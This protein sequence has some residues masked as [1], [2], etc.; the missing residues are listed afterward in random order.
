MAPTQIASRARQVLIWCFHLLLLVTP[1]LFTWF[2]EEL[3]EFNKMLFVYGITVLIAAAWL[4]KT[5]AIGKVEL[6][7]S[8]FTLLLG[9]FI[10]SQVLSTLFSIHVPTS[11]FG[12]YT[13]FNG[14]LLSLISYSVLY[15]IALQEIT[16]QEVKRLLTTLALAGLGIA[17]FAI[18]EHF[19]HAWSCVLIRQEFTTSCWVQDVQ[20]RI[21]GTFGQPNWLAAY[22]VTVIPVILAQAHGIWT[23]KNKS[24][25]LW[26]FSGVATLLTV[27]LIFTKS[28]SGW[29][30]LLAAMGALLGGAVWLWHQHRSKN[31]KQ[32]LPL[33][34]F[35]PLQ[36]VG[37]ALAVLVLL[38]VVFGNP[39][40]PGLLDRTT[41]SAPPPTAPVDRLEQGGTESGE[42]RMIVWRGAL[43]VGLRYPLVGSGVETFAYSYY[44]DRPLA[45]NLVS[46][47]DFL[48]NKAHNEFLNY[49]ATTGAVGVS[50]YILLHGWWIWLGYQ[51][52]FKK[53]NLTVTQQFYALGFAAGTLALAISNFFGFSTVMVS[54]LFFLYPAFTMIL[55]EDFVSPLSKFGFSAQR[56]T[57]AL[58][59]YIALGVV[60]LGAAYVLS[61]TVTTWVA[62]Y[63]FDQGKDNIRAGSTLEGL[64]QIESAIEMR[65]AQPVFTDTLSSLYAQVAVEYAQAG[66]TEAAIYAANQ[67]ITNSNTTLLLNPV[68]LNFYKSRIRVF[69]T[70]AQLN[71]EYLEQARATAQVAVQLSP[72]DPKLWYQ[73]GMIQFAQKERPLAE[74]SLN[75]ALQLKPD[76][77]QAL[78]GLAIIEASAPAETSE[79]ETTPAE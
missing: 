63:T 18:P 46:E 27:T 68:H 12:Y 24:K 25:L 75:K 78:E 53:K 52:F 9:A 42:I 5:I 41:P 7:H 49:W 26:L 1:F 71:P 11:I 72:T 69:S 15:F 37:G 16:P 34:S 58:S 44:L 48:Y 13:R 35:A 47:W 79:T 57:F 60:V 40:F 50:T 30:G 21:F 31:K 17:L 38:A 10:L 8:L 66:E 76:F 2:N 73:L 70:L 65:P 6:K 22:A 67:A 55:L 77:N 39:L 14:G 36:L 45:H 61:Q 32:S 20:H 51:V 62:D 64:K 29:L 23:Q 33:S 4:I 56:K 59:E 43:D 28:R 3:F 19:G 54:V 74:E